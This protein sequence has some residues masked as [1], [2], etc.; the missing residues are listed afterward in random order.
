MVPRQGLAG[1]QP[2]QAAPSTALQRAPVNNAAATATDSSS[3]SSSH[4]TSKQTK[5]DIVEQVKLQREIRNDLNEKNHMILKM[6]R[7][8][9]GRKVSKAY[10]INIRTS[11][12]SKISDIQRCQN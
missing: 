7:V 4:S 9:R 6:Q 1:R 3:S 12:D 10:M 8:Y 5:D 11:F 2:Q